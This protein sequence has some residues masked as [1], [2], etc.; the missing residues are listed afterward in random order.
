MKVIVVATHNERYFD[1]FIDSLK[2]YNIEPI[3]LGWGVK[4]T[5]HLMKDDLLEEYLTNNTKNDI[6]IFCDAFDCILIRDPKLLE[7]KFIESQKNLIVSTE[8]SDN[9]IYN[10]F[11]NFYF[12]NKKDE[13][14][15]TGMI[16][17]YRDT[18]LELLREVKKYRQDGINSNQRIWNIAFDSSKKIKNM[19]V[20][21]DYENNFFKNY[22]IFSNK[23]KFVNNKI[24]LTDKKTYPF[25]LQGNGN[26]DLNTLCK[27]LN[28]KTSKIKLEDK[29]KYM[30]AFYFYYVKPYQN[31]ILVIFALLLFIIYILIKY[32]E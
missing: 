31:F 9:D 12:K 2:K 3:I 6:I 21:L 10:Y 17:G 18:F 13:N 15:N 32:S 20:K 25:M 29:I 23:I 8:K 16:I 28:I 4:Y 14:L 19:N 24:Y 1:S 27:K 5:G 30:K 7:Q 11:K 22:N 26:K